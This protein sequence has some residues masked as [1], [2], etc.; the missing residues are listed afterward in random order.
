MAIQGRRVNW[1]MGDENSPFACFDAICTQFNVTWP[2]CGTVRDF[3]AVLTDPDCR[4]ESDFSQR[5]GSDSTCGRRVHAVQNKTPEQTSACFASIKS[6]AINGFNKYVFGFYSHWK[7]WYKSEK[8][9]GMCS[10]WH[11]T[12][13]G[14]AYGDMTTR[15]TGSL[16]CLHP[17]I[18]E[19]CIA[20]LNTC[21]CL[22][23]IRYDG[24]YW[25]N[26]SLVSEPVHLIA[27]H[28]RHNGRDV[29]SIHWR[30]DCLLSCLFRCR[31]MKTSKFRVT[32]LCEGN[33]PVTG[34]LASNAE[35]VSIWWRHH[36]HSW[37]PCHLLGE[38]IVATT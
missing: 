24:T 17:P 35:N 10:E 28:W 16:S 15:P 31:S 12:T 4:H 2:H 7:V 19:L 27:L 29:V 30:L 22:L 38:G 32:G 14:L 20:I 9:F 33:P 34:G 6:R 8:A 3:L 21:P 11:Y 37:T 23:A 13:R 1:K 5:D 25:M 36:G 18:P 26:V